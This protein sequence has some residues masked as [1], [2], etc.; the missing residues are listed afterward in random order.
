M[1]TLTADPRDE[2]TEAQVTSV[3]QAS[4][5]EVDFGCDL[6]DLDLAF[7][8][9]ISDDLVGGTIDWEL[10]RRI[11]RTCRL[12]LSRTLTWGVD[13][14]RPWMTLSD[15]SVT[16]KWYVGV[17]MLTTPDRMVG[18]SL[19]TYEADGY[20]RI[21]LLDRQVGETY[22]IT[23]GTTY[24]QALTDVFA[25]AGLSGVLI[26]GS[27]A[28]DT[29][30]ADRTWSLVAQDMSDPDQTDT[31]AT[32]LR[33]VND[34][35]QAIN[36]RS[37]WCDEL[38][39]FRCQAYQSPTVRATEWTFD[40]DDEYLTII[41]EDR[42]LSEDVWGTPN[43]WVFRRT[44]GGTGVEGDGIYTVTNQSDGPTSIDQRGLTWTSVVDYEA[45]SQAKL[46]ELGDRRVEEDRRVTSLLDVTTGPFPG[47][48]HADVYAYEDAEIGDRKVQARS[49]SMSV[50]GG[51]VSWQWEKV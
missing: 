18:E 2:L 38:G 30:P 29:L 41:G 24:R 25:D 39:T 40:A 4:T 42:R 49:W 33:V 10:Y 13:L 37:V 51:D 19:D 16:A 26:D 8:A 44:N 46:V 34:L 22:T 3:L 20:D 9:D 36:F 43:R 17:F 47:A 27:A 50:D 35:L 48:G 6:L 12:R 15:G 32:W 31:P 11:H 28:D 5:V 1:Q 23:S 21:Y 14:V 7:V 45:A